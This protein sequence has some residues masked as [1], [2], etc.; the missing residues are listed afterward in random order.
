ME[1]FIKGTL[2]IFGMLFGSVL[3]ALAFCLIVKATKIW[4]SY[5]P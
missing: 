4:N 2:F 3:I 1:D 5:K